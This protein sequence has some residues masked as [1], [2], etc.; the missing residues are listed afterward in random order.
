MKLRNMTLIYLAR[1]FGNV[2]IELIWKEMENIGMCPVL[3]KAT[4]KLYKKLLE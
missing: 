2:P 4:E 1:A 3:I